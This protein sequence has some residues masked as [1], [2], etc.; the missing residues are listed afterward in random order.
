MKPGD[1]AAVMAHIAP[2]AIFV[3]SGIIE[4][5]EEYEKNHLPADIGFE[6]QVSGVRKP[7]QITTDGN[8]AWIVAETAF[9]GTFEGSPISFVST[10]LAVLTLMDG[11]WLIRS[12][13]WSSRR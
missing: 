6:K 10:Q 1:A 13:H 9:D 3:E 5:R 2:G 8:T 4:T 7:V 12:I 11:R